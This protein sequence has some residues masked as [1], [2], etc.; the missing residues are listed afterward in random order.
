MLNFFIC[1]HL[2]GDRFQQ[3]V[4]PLHLLFRP[5]V[6][7]FKGSVDALPLAVHILITP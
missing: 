4:T 3:A 6:L 1:L 2:R 5:G 7:T